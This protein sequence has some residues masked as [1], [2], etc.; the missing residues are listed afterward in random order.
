MAHALEAMSQVASIMASIAAFL[1]PP[2]AALGVLPRAGPMRALVLGVSSKWGFL[3]PAFTM[4]QRAQD[5]EAL[6]KAIYAQSAEQYIV[7]MGPK[8]RG[9]P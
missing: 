6:K 4:S 5:C 1:A 9:D 8:V 3:R 2:A 7:V